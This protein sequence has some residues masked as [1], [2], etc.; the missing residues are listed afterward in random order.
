ML[1]EVTS[2][3][4]E[5]PAYFVW[6]GRGN[7]PNFKVWLDHDIRRSGLEKR[8]L[9]VGESNDPGVF[10]MGSDVFVL[11]SREETFSLVAV[12]AMVRGVPAIAFRDAGARRR[13]WK[14]AVRSY[15][16]STSIRWLAPYHDF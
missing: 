7:D 10:F 2:N 11:P 8:I 3:R 1:H 6:I 12:E 4:I 15:R 14:V 16:I 13:C 9:F 5:Q